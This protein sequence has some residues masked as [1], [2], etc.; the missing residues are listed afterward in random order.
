MI[1]KSYEKNSTGWLALLTSNLDPQ[2]YY[3]S[4]STYHVRELRFPC[5]LRRPHHTKQTKN[6]L[7]WQT[8]GQRTEAMLISRPR[9]IRQR[10]HQMLMRAQFWCTAVCRVSQRS[11]QASALFQGLSRFL[12]RIPP[13]WFLIRRWVL[14]GQAGFWLGLPS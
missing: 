10:C 11:P 13:A 5:R 7:S 6:K 4:S 12:Q 8:R 2:I 9:P 3:V 14:Y 1:D